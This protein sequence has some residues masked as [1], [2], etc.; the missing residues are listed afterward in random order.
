[1]RAAAGQALPATL[2]RM[3]A[4]TYMCFMRLHQFMEVFFLFGLILCI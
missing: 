3:L 1:M 2:Q 4:Y